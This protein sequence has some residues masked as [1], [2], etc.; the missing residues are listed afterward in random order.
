MICTYVLFWI[1]AHEERRERSL[2]EP[3]FLARIS[4]SSKITEKM[5]DNVQSFY[6]IL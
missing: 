5:I 6:I 3:G 2:S 1:C 4:A